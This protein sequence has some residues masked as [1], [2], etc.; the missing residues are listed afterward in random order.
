[1]PVESPGPRF[2]H[3]ESILRRWE[4]LGERKTTLGATLIGRVPHVGPEAWL[5]EVYKGLSEQELAVLEEALPSPI[6]V[7]FQDFL[8]RAN[9]LKMF[10]DRMSISGFRAAISRNGDG[11]YQPYDLRE[12]ND[13]D[14][15]PSRR[16]ESILVFGHCG[17]NESA[18]F[19][20]LKLGPQQSRVG[21]TLMD[22]FREVQSWPDFWTWV[23]HETERLAR[24]CD[25]QG[26]RKSVE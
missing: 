22:S 17:E 1:M 5:H 11:R 18:V 24:N 16:P 26:D 14:G 15:P 13:P 21:M 8:R 12:D 19:F 25:R 2:Q 6:P 3:L 4:H 9:G 20:D 23:V 10:S 7:V